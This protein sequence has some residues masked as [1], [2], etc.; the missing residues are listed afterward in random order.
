MSVRAK[1]MIALVIVLIYSLGTQIIDR[2]FYTIMTN[3]VALSQLEDSPQSFTN[4]ASYKLAW[5]IWEAGWIVIALIL[6]M[7]FWKNIS[8]WYNSIG[9]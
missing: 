3:E 9:S 1:I 8:V 4:L 6:L 2:V 5:Q 7:M